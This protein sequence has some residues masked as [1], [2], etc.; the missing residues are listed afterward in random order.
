MTGIRAWTGRPVAR[1]ASALIAGALLPAA[2]APFG[3]WPLALICPAALLALIL[4]LDSRK[5]ALCGWFFGAGMFGT[6]SSWVYVSIHDFGYAPI[7]LAAALTLGFCLGLALLPAATVWIW[8]RFLRARRGGV[9]LGFPAMWVLGEWCRIWL[10][11]GFPWLYLGY[12]QLDGPL[13]GWAPVSGVLGLGALLSFSAAALV[14]ALQRGRRGLSAVAVAALLWAL[15]PA[16]SLIDWV[17]PRGAPLAVA[18]VQGNIPQELK[19]E[20]GHLEAT[21]ETYEELSEPLWGTDLIV[22]PEAA[23]PAY[24]DRLSD[25]LQALARRS[26]VAGSTLLTGVPT[27]FSN[28]DAKRGFDA[29]NSVLAVGADSGIYHKRH[30]V[31]FGEYVP[32]DSVLRGLIAFFDLPMSSFS[33]GPADQPL[34]AVKGLQLAPFICYEIVFPDMVASALPDADVLLTVSNDTWFGR[35]IGPLQHLQMARMRALENGR[36]LIRAT[37]NGVSALVDARGRIL[38][39]GGQFTREVV[40]GEI[41]PTSGATPFSRAGSAPV[42]ALAIL[43]LAAVRAS[44]KPQ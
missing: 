40:R 17:R 14:V 8:A 43:A 29:F 9:L 30:L 35:S 15:G 3:I 31:P 21:L 20:P 37:N 7:P 34:L 41:Q 42:L 2:F 33:A 4:P 11:T 24:L 12:S 25:F 5:A 18:M 6:G 32:L 26:A 19:W 23:L 39:R 22:W 28:P 10:L 16:L 38:V 36:P 27:R 1:H 13:A 44:R